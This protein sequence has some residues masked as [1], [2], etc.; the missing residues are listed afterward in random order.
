MKRAKVL[1]GGTFDILH[2][3]HIFLLKEASKYGDVIV[4]VARDSTVKR[5]K[6]RDP[7]FNEEHRLMM[8][9]SVKY[10]KKAILGKEST[11]I[12]EIVEELKPDIIVLG[13]DQN[14]EE[15]I[16]KR[17]PE[18]KVIKL[19]KRVKFGELCSSSDIIRKILKIY[20]N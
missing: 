5:V 9:G 4:V 16:A 18:I 14:M 10:V 19:S 12:L 13:P 2:P 17:F 3:G 11:D 15:I 8:V 1:V 20:C 7:I 6:G